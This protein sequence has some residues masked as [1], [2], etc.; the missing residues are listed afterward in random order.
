[1]RVPWG[2]SCRLGDHHWLC[3]PFGGVGAPSHACFPR[4]LS[5][6]HLGISHCSALVG[7]GVPPSQSCIDGG[8][9]PRA[10]AVGGLRIA[11]EGRVEGGG[12]PQGYDSVPL[13]LTPS[14]SPLSPLGCRQY[15]PLSTGPTA[16]LSS[17]PLEARVLQA[18]AT[19]YCN[20]PPSPACTAA[21]PSLQFAFFFTSFLTLGYRSPVHVAGGPG[22]PCLP[23]AIDHTRRRVGLS[24]DFDVCRS[25]PY[26]LH[27][28]GS[29]VAY[30]SGV[31]IDSSG[32]RA[33]VVHLK[34]FCCRAEDHRS[35]L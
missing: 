5:P 29:L 9:C 28:Q 30:V 7:A 21:P 3:P 4:G 1:M 26:L 24:F 25:S 19:Y 33:P 27:L 2:R 17:Q 23:R 15:R 12:A 14:L 8:Q 18:M 34:Q 35:G 10:C 6:S 20:S 32:I 16:R 22:V 13:W 11:A 31:L